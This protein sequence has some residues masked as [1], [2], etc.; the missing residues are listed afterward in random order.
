[1]IALLFTGIQFHGCHSSLIQFEF[2]KVIENPLIS[3]FETGSVTLFIVEQ[4]D[5]KLLELA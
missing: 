1:M 5:C 2:H 3:L 4:L